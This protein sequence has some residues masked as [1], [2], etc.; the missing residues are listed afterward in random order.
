MGCSPR[1]TRVISWV[2]VVLFGLLMLCGPNTRIRDLLVMCVLFSGTL[3]G[4]A[5]CHLLFRAPSPDKHRTVA[6]ALAT[7]I[8]SVTLCIHPWLPH[9]PGIR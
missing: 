5:G 4:L 7:A 8:L 3:A 1:E 2:T 6:F 9:S